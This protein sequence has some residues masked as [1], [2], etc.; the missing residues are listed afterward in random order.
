MKTKKTSKQP[1]QLYFFNTLTYG[2]G[3]DAVLDV[4]GELLA[5]SFLVLFL[6]AS[7]V[8]GDVLA[9]DVGPVDV[10]VELLGLLVVAGETLLAVGDLDSAIGG[11]LQ[12][13]E[14]LGA[15]ARTGQADVEAGAESSRT[16]IVVLDAVVLSIDLGVA[17]VGAV[18]VELLQH[19]KLNE[20]TVKMCLETGY[21]R[22]NVVSTMRLSQTLSLYPPHMT[23]TARS[24]Q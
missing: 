2:I 10:S 16:V 3:S 6:K 1:N 12:G 21:T 20:Y 4:E 18:Q 15:G 22:W 11:S 23:I 5:V 7:H 13:G 14:D 19:L 17:L 8:V 9:K 24:Q